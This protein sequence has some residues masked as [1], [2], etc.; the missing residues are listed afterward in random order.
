MAQ[1]TLLEKRLVYKHRGQ[2]SV[3]RLTYVESCMISYAWCACMYSS[4]SG[5]GCSS[6]GE[7]L[8]NTYSHEFD[9][10][11]HIKP[12]MVVYTV[13]PALRGSRQEVQQLVHTC[14]A[15]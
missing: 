9:S 11:P 7:D 12:G 3:R 15:S 1:D 4:D 13:L 5:W 14:T 6:V 8:L 10:Q 2:T